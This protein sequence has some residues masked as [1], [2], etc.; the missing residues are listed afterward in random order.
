MSACL[1]NYAIFIKYRTIS[2]PSQ[3]T[4]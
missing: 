4:S 1:A 3:T 2:L